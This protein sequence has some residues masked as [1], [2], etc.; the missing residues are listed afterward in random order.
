[1]DR[2]P[3]ESWSAS[4]CDTSD[5]EEEEAGDPIERGASGHELLRDKDFAELSPTST[6]ASSA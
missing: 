1:M 5:G 4:R 2:L 3:P 6:G